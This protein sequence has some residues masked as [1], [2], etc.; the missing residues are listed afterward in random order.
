MRLL[1]P[2][3]QAEEGGVINKGTMGETGVVYHFS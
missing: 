3:I 2:Y 1:G